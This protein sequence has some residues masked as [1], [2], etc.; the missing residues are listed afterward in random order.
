MEDDRHS[1]RLIVLRILE[2]DREPHR[3]QG[4]EGANAAL[5]AFASARTKQSLLAKVDRKLAGLLSGWRWA[6]I[7]RPIP[8]S[9][10]IRENGPRPWTLYSQKS[11]DLSRAV[12]INVI[13][14]WLNEVV[15]SHRRLGIAL[16]VPRLVHVQSV[17]GRLSR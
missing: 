9:T 7:I 1:L 16:A 10:M 12:Y 14:T 15:H 3:D 5:V 8:G 2:V 13:G 11:A 6:G 4:G 17:A